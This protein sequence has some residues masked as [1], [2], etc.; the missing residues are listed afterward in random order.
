M[1]AALVGC[2]ADFMLHTSANEYAE[3]LEAGQRL[4]LETNLAVIQ[5]LDQSIMRMRHSTHTRTLLE[6]A[7]VR[8]CQLESLDE[9]AGIVAQLRAGVAANSPRLAA[10]RPAAS[11]PP[12][13]EKNGK[14]S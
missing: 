6:I 12:M 4:G 2:E 1:M 9:L 10:T 13:P 7:L 11:A 8:I 14:N 5:I 3:L